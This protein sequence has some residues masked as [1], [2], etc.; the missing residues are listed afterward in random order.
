[1]GN[2]LPKNRRLD[3]IQIEYINRENNK[4]IFSSNKININNFDDDVLHIKYHN[5]LLMSS[6]F[7]SQ[8]LTSGNGDKIKAAIDEHIKQHRERLQAAQMRNQILASSQKK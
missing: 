4:L 1:M 8:I 3:K 6:E 7:E 2:R 5:R